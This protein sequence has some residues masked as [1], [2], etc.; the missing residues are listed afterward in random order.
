MGT[1]KN[2][3]SVVKIRQINLSA[4]EQEEKLISDLKSLPCTHEENRYIS[5]PSVPVEKNITLTGLSRENAL[6]SV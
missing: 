6:K 4:K 5:M 1:V 2:D 3:P